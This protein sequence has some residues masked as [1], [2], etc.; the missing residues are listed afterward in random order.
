MRLPF[1]PTRTA[2]RLARG[3][4]GRAGMTV[5]DDRDARVPVPVR[6]V[7]SAHMAGPMRVR[8]GSEAHPPRL[9]PAQRQER[10]R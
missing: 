3:S 4:T 1:D 7:P 5:R 10:P 8:R 9:M 6:A 2:L